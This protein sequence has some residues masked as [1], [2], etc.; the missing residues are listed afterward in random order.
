[1]DRRDFL[2]GA[3][4]LTATAAYGSSTPLLRHPYI[5]GIDLSAVSGALSIDESTLSLDSGW[6]FKA[7]DDLD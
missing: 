3:A 6:K 5:N 2:R 4:A 1:M 7:G